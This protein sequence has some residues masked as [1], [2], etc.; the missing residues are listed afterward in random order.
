MPPCIGHIPGGPK[1]RS[2][3]ESCIA[4]DLYY[5]ASSNLD[6]WMSE[7]IS[8]GVWSC[9]H[10]RLFICDI[11][12]LKASTANQYTSLHVFTCSFKSTRLITCNSFDEVN[13]LIKKLR[14]PDKLISGS[15]RPRSLNDI[16]CLETRVARVTLMAYMASLRELGFAS[17]LRERHPLLSL[18]DHAFLLSVYWSTGCRRW[19]SCTWKGACYHDCKWRHLSE[20]VKMQAKKLILQSCL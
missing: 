1:K 3:L 12:H 18:S 4:V 15:R 2:K 10:A 6:A 7:H 13:W 17:H 8:T 9:I 19:M 14:W 16:P 5:G 11:L 20:Y